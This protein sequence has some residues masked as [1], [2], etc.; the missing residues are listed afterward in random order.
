MAVEYPFQLPLKNNYCD[1][2]FVEGYFNEIEIQE[3]EKIWQTADH[4]K[5]TVVAEGDKELEHEIRKSSV[6]MIKPEDAHK[7]VFDKLGALAIQANNER[8][9]F[10]ILG[11]KEELQLA[12]Y[13]EGHYFDWHLDFSAGQASMRKLSMSVQLSDSEDYEGGDLEIMVNTNHVKV[14]RSKGTVIIFPSFVM[15]RVTPV[16][17]GT[18]KS[19]VGWISGPPYR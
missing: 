19:L 13:G 4:E 18:R 11:F 16:T 2:L 1:F 6:A 15:H 8:Y 12:E 10:D 17:K 7:W 14:P 3:L 5:A 9:W